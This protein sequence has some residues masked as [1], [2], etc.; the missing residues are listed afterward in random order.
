MKLLE[1]AKRFL[2]GN[3]VFISYAR[4]D[5]ANYAL[6]LA[7]RLTERGLQCYLDQWGTPPGQ[8]S[9]LVLRQLKRSSLLVVIA[10]PAAGIS[11]N[12][13]QEIAEF[14]PTGR[15]V[16][17]VSV[18][19]AL[20]GAQWFEKVRGITITRE[21]PDKFDA[22]T[23][24]ESTLSR[25]ENAEGF[26]RRNLR[27]R[28][29]FVITA[30]AIVVM[31]AGGS[32][33]LRRA[34]TTL[35]RVQRA[36]ELETRGAAIAATFRSGGGELTSL[37]SAIQ[38]AIDLNEL[39]REAPYVYAATTPVLA[40]ETILHGI[41][42][43]LQI[44]VHTS[45]VRA[46]DFDPT[47]KLIAVV[48][49]DGVIGGQ[50]DVW[51][52]TP[53]GKVVTHWNIGKGGANDVHFSADGSQ[54]VITPQMV[55]PPQTFDLAGRRIEKAG[56][57]P[58]PIGGE[59]R[60]LETFGNEVIAR[61]G[62]KSIRVHAQE[63]GKFDRLQW[64]NAD[65]FAGINDLGWFYAWNL[66][67]LLVGRFSVG[68][69]RFTS[70][71]HNKTE[72]LLAVGESD[73]VTI[74]EFGGRV[75]SRFDAHGGRL[76]SL[77]FTPDG[78]S[79]VTSGAL[80]DI[81]VWD[82]EGNIEARLLGHR[83]RV[84]AIRF[85][86]DGTG[87]LSAGLDGTV[88]LW[89][90]SNPAETQV[91]LRRAVLDV[92]VGDDGSLIALSSD[93]SVRRLDPSGRE[94]G[95][96]E[97]VPQGGDGFFNGRLSADGRTA[98][99]S[100]AQNKAALYD[101]NGPTAREL[102]R[103]DAWLLVARFDAKGRRAC[104]LG[105][106]GILNIIDAAGSTHISTSDVRGWIMGCAFD[107]KADRIAGLRIDRT[108]RFWNIKGEPAGQFDSKHVR[109]IDIDFSPDGSRIVTAGDDGAVRIWTRDGQPIAEAFGHSGPVIGVRFS[110]EGARVASLGSD[111][112]VFLWDS[113]G[114]QL[115]D[116]AA[117]ADPIVHEV[118][119][120]DFGNRGLA[121]SPDGKR[122]AAGLAQGV[123]KVWHV[124]PLDELIR[125]GQAWLENR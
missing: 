16:L 42:E 93:G 17:P 123:I 72:R 68:R 43:Q 34:R 40:L 90:R 14:L 59:D 103:V 71:S 53:Q 83:G 96:L 28:R 102:T 73:Q 18:G 86:S 79:L 89:R 33:L 100:V 48:E 120:G 77:S 87:I 23:P 66:D 122:L 64:V 31:V 6:A 85:S 9:P 95:A 45:E 39:P 124:G 44:P 92:V 118:S 15:P 78:R 74:Y 37:Q 22:A 101:V 104:V 119:G 58:V 41:H 27:L 116:F 19:D 60:S 49:G 109:P 88:R 80:G 55:G 51:L 70:F 10:S 46:V 62:A 112:H 108:V 65:T 3:D 47:G 36:T 106:S 5:S 30:I 21:T 54:I 13:A 113:A 117:K 75:L 2:A 98:I 4:G 125:R 97:L 94:V 110:P 1:Q 67:G 25:I 32:I 11:P 76:S 121:F 26:T 24:A 114:R 91:R 81:L 56:V 38:T 57:Q 111:G 12:V 82:L 69:V 7:S 20:E 63:D 84:R 50:S 105:P 99:L 29:I 107:P 8:L 115:A 35:N 52:W 61:S